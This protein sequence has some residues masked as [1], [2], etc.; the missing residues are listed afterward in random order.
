VDGHGHLNEGLLRRGISNSGF[1]LDGRIKRGKILVETVGL[2]T[3]LNQFPQPAAV[4]NQIQAM[5]NPK[6]VLRAMARLTQEALE[7]NGAG[8]VKNVRAFF[9]VKVRA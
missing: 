7:L 3:R 5:E 2:T 1:Q 4:L 6:T 8:N 9:K